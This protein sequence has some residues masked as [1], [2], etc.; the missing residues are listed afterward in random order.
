MTVDQKEPPPPLRRA[1]VLISG[2]SYLARN[3]QSMSDIVSFPNRGTVVRLRSN[4]RRDHPRERSIARTRETTLGK[5][6]RTRVREHWRNHRRARPFNRNLCQHSSGLNYHGRLDQL[7]PNRD[8]VVVATTKLSRSLRAPLWD[9][10]QTFS[11]RGPPL[12][13]DRD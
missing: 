12:R 9:I 6:T 4:R 8:A 7:A 10:N 11:P 5:A 3:L 2:I 1:H 13:G